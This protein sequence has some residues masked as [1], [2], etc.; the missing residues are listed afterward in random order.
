[1]WEQPPPAV[2]GPQALRFY[3]AS[4]GARIRN[5]KPSTL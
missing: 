2:P 5:E 4:Q 1:M 3:P